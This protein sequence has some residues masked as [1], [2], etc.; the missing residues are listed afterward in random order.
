MLRYVVA[1]LHHDAQAHHASLA[2]TYFN[3]TF[4]KRKKTRKNENALRGSWSS[5]ARCCFPHFLSN[6]I[7]NA[8]SI[9]R[10]CDDFLQLFFF[11]LYAF[12]V[13]RIE[14]REDN[15][16]VWISVRFWCC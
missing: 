2:D 3:R 14:L 1:T 10:C 12:L 4:A 9:C 7:A 15:G 13:V 16:L 8:L 5:V 6:P 11:F